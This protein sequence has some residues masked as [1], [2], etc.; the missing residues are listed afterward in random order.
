MKQEIES[1]L[2][3]FGTIL[4][5]KGFAL[6]KDK[7]VI[8]KY[9]QYN[10]KTISYPQHKKIS[11]AGAEYYR[12]PRGLCSIGQCGRTLPAKI[13][14]KVKINL[15][16]YQEVVVDET[17]SILKEKYHMLLQM[18]TGLGKSFVAAGL[19]NKLRHKTCIV[20]SN[21][22]L[23]TQM[24][25]DLIKAYEG[26][27]SDY[28][29]S[30]SCKKEEDADIVLVVI[31]TAVKLPMSFWESFGLV[32]L[33]EVHAYCSDTFMEVFWRADY[34]HYVLGMTATPKR[35]DGMHSLLFMH[36][37]ETMHA[38][39]MYA[40]LETSP[41]NFFGRAIK[42]EYSGPPEFTKKLVNKNGMV[43]TIKMAKQFLED[44]TRMQFVA[45]IVSKLYD[46]GKNIYVF[47]QLKEPL[48]DLR[49]AMI[50]ATGGDKK[51][52]KRM[53]KDT[54]IVTGDTTQD[55]AQEAKDTA[56]VFLT[57]YALSSKGLSIIKFDALVF[58][59]PMKNNMEQICGRIF[60]KNSD[61]TIERLIIDIVDTKTSIAKQ[62]YTRK[63]EY[64]VRKLPITAVKLHHETFEE[65]LQAVFKVIDGSPGELDEDYEDSDDEPT[66]SFAEYSSV[67]D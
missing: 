51:Y 34:A 11:V 9:I 47:C 39:V 28:I 64:S 4:G 20:V 21:K 26:S 46:A 63:K 38:K 52:R 60:R 55:D 31:N 37:G 59:T 49:R 43:S 14:K 45:R 10:R 62:W 40:H 48:N 33:D 66:D 36:L 16:D 7:A 3:D 1:A 2:T 50:A 17:E 12:V 67:T 65:D 57:T 35:L 29:P 56:K 58:L 24:C 19:I 25:N 6:V 61:E 23:R 32:I 8:H 41:S 5:K 42:V 54:H 15:K 44:T 27:G 22:L 18:D 13:L 53:R 30:I